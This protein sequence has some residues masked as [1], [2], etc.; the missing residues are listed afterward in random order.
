MQYNEKLDLMVKCFVCVEWDD[1]CGFADSWMDHKDIYEMRPHRCITIGRLMDVT[2]EYITI[3]ATWDEAATI[4]SDVNCIPI[5][6]IRNI[7]VIRGD[8]ASA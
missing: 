6:C 3:A 8:N 2:E 4:V 5:G 1:I 7:N